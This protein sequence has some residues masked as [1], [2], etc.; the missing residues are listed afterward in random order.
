MLTLK[1]C[2]S[3]RTPARDAY[4]GLANFPVSQT[5]VRKHFCNYCAT[6]IST[7]YHADVRPS[8]ALTM[9]RLADLRPSDV[10]PGS[11][12]T[13][14]YK[15]VSGYQSTTD[16]NF[17]IAR[18]LCA[19]ARVPRGP[20]VP[21]AD[22]RGPTSFSH[23][24]KILIPQGTQAE[25]ALLE[26]PFIGFCSVSV[27]LGTLPEPPSGHPPTLIVRERSPVVSSGAQSTRRIPNRLPL[28]RVPQQ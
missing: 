9:E 10:S 12:Q 23:V 6:R 8:R 19:I 24:R 15:G 13:S 28:W 14:Q 25:T 1:A 20:D 11:G 26:L 27:S 18:H 4:N 5:G 21:I 3:G 17:R 2:G 22:V 16:L 7:V